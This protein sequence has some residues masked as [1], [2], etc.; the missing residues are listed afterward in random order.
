[1][2][3]I[4]L[5]LVFALILVL[6][7]C[8]GDLL[9]NLDSQEQIVDDSLPPLN[10]RG[11]YIVGGLSGN[12]ISTVVSEIDLYDPIE[13]EWHPAITTLPT[14]VSFFGAVGYQGKIYI[15]GGYDGTGTARDLVQIYDTSSGLWTSGSPLPA[16]RANIDASLNDGYIYVLSG[17]SSPANNTTY[18]SNNTTYRYNITTDSWVA[19]TAPGTNRINLTQYAYGGTVYYLGARTANATINVMHEG[20]LP[21]P[22]GT[23]ALYTTPTDMTLA[24]IGIAADV[25]TKPSGT[26]YLIIAGGV[27]VM[28]GANANYVF[29]AGTAFTPLQTVQYIQAPFTG[30]VVDGSG[31][32]TM[33]QSLP[34]TTAYCSGVIVNDVYYI[35]GGTKTGIPATQPP[36]G[37][38]TTFISNLSTFPSLTWQTGT[39]MPRGRYGHRAVKINLD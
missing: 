25:Y 38:S 29:N 24:K 33:P 30:T 11:I 37:M 13:N 19:R 31:W 16:I 27:S 10:L 7:S 4:Q 9:F 36:S 23:D 1:M 3:K 34:D 35:F 20:Y 2:K 5:M 12:G 28:T 21:V 18:S 32:N 39:A 15:I 22:T 14:P 6:S 17:S 8:T 26:S